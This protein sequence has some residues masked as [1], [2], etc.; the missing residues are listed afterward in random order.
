MGRNH[1]AF[2]TQGNSTTHSYWPNIMQ[3]QMMAIEKG[4]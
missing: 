2:F 3:K 1:I 4:G